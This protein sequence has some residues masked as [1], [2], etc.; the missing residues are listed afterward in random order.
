MSPLATYVV[1]TL[2]TLLAIVLLAWLVLALARRGGMG[3]AA[4][5]LE[6]VGRLPLDARRAVYLV[7]VNEKI[8][9]LGASE[10]G[11]SK[12]GELDREALPTSVAQLEPSS[13]R[14]VLARVLSRSKGAAV[15]EPSHGSGSDRGGDAT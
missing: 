8:F 1:E 4:G 13:F 12:L 3:R 6:L 15:S 11:L 9:V 10:A 5:P 2:V 14:E 7:R